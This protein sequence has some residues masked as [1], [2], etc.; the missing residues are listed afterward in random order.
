MQEEPMA[1]AKTL[2]LSELLVDVTLVAAVVLEFLEVSLGTL[3]IV[4][5]I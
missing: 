2:R 4:A 5:A 1:V 3:V